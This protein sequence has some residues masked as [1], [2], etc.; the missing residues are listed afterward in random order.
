MTARCACSYRVTGDPEVGNCGERKLVH[1]KGDAKMFYQ[2]LAAPALIGME[3]TGNSQS[4]VDIW[5]ATPPVLLVL[6][7]PRYQF[8]TPVDG[9]IAQALRLE[10]ATF[11]ENVR[12]QR[13]SR[14]FY[15]PI[16]QGSLSSN[17]AAFTAGPAKSQ[18]STVRSSSCVEDHSFGEVVGIKC[19]RRR[20]RI[21]RETR[22]RSP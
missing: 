7:F 4:F 16:F 12:G 11:S 8:A 1:A 19:Q 3:A 10:G 2:A 5:H 14:G 6:S 9:A 13:R 21:T 18:M 22:R 20:A 15:L 17:H